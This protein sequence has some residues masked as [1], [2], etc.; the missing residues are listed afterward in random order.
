V[1]ASD[2]A[3]YVYV[4]EF[5]VRPERVAAFE[6]TYGPNGE[7]AALFGRAPGYLGT[8]L[9]R[10]ASH[11]HR[12]LTIDRWR[13]EEDYQQFREHYAAEYRAIDERSETMTLQERSLG[14]YEE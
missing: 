2:V 6:R 1:S 12:Y 4:W 3:G 14:T 11:A 13:S 9:L 7:W 8:L 10:D 5:L